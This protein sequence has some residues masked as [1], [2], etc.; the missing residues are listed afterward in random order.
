M[1]LLTMKIQFLIHE[2]LKIKI[3]LLPGLNKN[4]LRIDSELVCLLVSRLQKCVEVTLDP[5]VALGSNFVRELTVK[6]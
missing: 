2:S 1:E 5:M 6:L 3:L 4:V